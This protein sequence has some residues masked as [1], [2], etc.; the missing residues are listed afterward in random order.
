V[1]FKQQKILLTGLPGSGKHRIQKLLQTQFDLTDGTVF[2]GSDLHSN[3]DY[4]QAWCIID[5]RSVF[6]SEK[7]DLA[8]SH[9]K[10]LLGK[11]NG[12][13]FNF[14]EAADLDAQS[15]WAQWVRQNSPELP[16]VRVLNQ[17]FPA[18][19]QGFE[20]NKLN[21]PDQFEKSEFELKNLQTYEFNVGTVY[22]DHLLMGLDNSK[23]NL[24]MQI[25]RVQAVV[26]TFE[27]ENLVA[28]EGTA[29]RW[30]NYAADAHQQPGWIK[31]QGV[32]LDQAW[33][34]EIVQASLL[35]P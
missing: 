1:L 33:L 31:I 35:R 19:W 24:G 26:D 6:T 4:E 11:V 21:R 17:R 23:Q 12:V 28:I 34:Q 8:E 25:L 10:A 15:F 20:L 16:I 13:V 29:N 22:L 32:D 27:Y 18:S 7:D 3:L 5:V 2:V 14:M 30:D 9:L